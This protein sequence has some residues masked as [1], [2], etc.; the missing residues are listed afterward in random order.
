M[1]KP[2]AALPQASPALR[3]VRVFRLGWTAVVVLL[4]SV[5][6]LLNWF[7][8]PH[9]FHYTWIVP[10][11]PEDSFAYLAWSQ[12]AA[13][14]SLLFHLKYTALPHSAFLFQP[15]FLLCGW[16][17][18]LLA[19]DIGVVHWVVKAVGVVLFL[20]TFYGYTDY[21]GLDPLESI[22]ASILLGT[23]AGL[24]GLFVFFDLG[25]VLR[26]VPVDLWLVDANTYWSL[27][28]NPLFPYSLTLLL[29]VIYWADRG[30]RD[31]R[32]SDLW[33]SGVASGALTLIHPYSQPVLFA[34]ALLATVVRRR[35]KALGYLGRYLAALL[36]FVLYVALVS[37]LHPLASRH[38]S[39]GE[40]RSPSVAAYALGF[41]IPL[42]LAAAGLAV[43]RGPV[44]RR[45]WQ[46]VV[47]FVLS[48]ALSYLPIW[49]QRKLIFGAHVPLCILA[50]I[51]FALLLSKATG[52]RLRP[53]AA[54]GAA[55]ILLPLLTS[56][57][58]YLLA[59]QRTQ[60]RDNADGSYFISDEMMQGLEFLR[61]TSRQD[62]IVLATPATSRLIPAFSGN[63]VVWGHWAQAVDR[64]ERLQWLA[65]LWNRDGPRRA[66]DFWGA[67]I[68]Y[69][70]ADGGFKRVLEQS[71][72]GWQSILREAEKVFENGSVVIY[73][74]RSQDH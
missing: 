29:L 67:G 55:V 23:S 24:G 74:R 51:S 45:Y 48:L 66:H 50:A 52:A 72:E 13:H 41:G 26:I 11:Y 4:T 16:L 68:R 28:W 35:A 34:F 19:C 58:V 14:G 36:P 5:P 69:I 21:L 33:L 3:S 71:P 56:T 38:R 1:P 53:W 37:E 30:T 18:R 63:T 39:L 32:K 61:A 8:T 47:W 64:E 65:D 10:P 31:A 70:F 62:D 9:G 17:S 44:L 73:E 25:R 49:F 12:Q 15:F 42:L 57:S 20:M 2:A 7:W 60:V 43:G 22:V 27:L 40:M 6:Y 54:A 59:S 46:V